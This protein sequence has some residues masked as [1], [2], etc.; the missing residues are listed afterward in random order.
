MNEFS[1][2][3]LEDFILAQPDAR[4]VDFNDT[5][6]RRLTCG[7]MMVQFGREVGLD[8]TYAGTYAYYLS[9]GSHQTE[10][11]ATIGQTF[12]FDDYGVS[13][14]TYKTLKEAVLLRRR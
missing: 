7:C 14:E 1:R 10:I 3:E 9:E 6:N 2:K 8:F 12:L 5:R 4:L 13:H 11:V